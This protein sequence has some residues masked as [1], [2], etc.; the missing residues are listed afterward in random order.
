[1]ANMSKN[2][3]FGRNLNSKCQKNS[4]LGTIWKQ[5]SK[6][7]LFGKVFDGNIS[8]LGTIWQQ[9]FLFGW[10]LNSQHQKNSLLR[11]VW[12]Q[13]SKISFLGNILMAIYPFWESFWCQKFPFLESL[14]LRQKCQIISFFRNIVMAEIYKISYT[15]MLI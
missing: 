6:N 4:L 11:M 3:L 7:F 12:W 1:M 13:V 15:R 9:N 5:V 14:F 10:N 2:F 8:F